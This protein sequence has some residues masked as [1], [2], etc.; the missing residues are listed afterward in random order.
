MNLPSLRF[1][2]WWISPAT[3]RTTAKAKGPNRGPLAGLDA[4]PQSL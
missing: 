1:L 2:P 3:P 4:T